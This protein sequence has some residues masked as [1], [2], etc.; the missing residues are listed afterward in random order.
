MKAIIAKLLG[1]AGSLM[2]LSGCSEGEALSRI[3][4]S[5]QAPE[6]K[7][8]SQLHRLHFEASTVRA[9]KV[10]TSGSTT[11]LLGRIADPVYGDFS[12]EFVSQVRSGRGFRFLHEPIG[13]KIDSVRLILTSPRLEGNENALMKIGVY[14]IKG[15]EHSDLESSESLD[16]LRQSAQLLGQV[17]GNVKQYSSTKRV[18][19][20]DVVR[21]ITLPLDLGVGERIYRASKEHPEYFQTQRS[22][23][24][25]VLGGLL[26]TPLAGSGAVVQVTGIELSIYYTYL[27]AS[28]EK[29]VGRERFIDTKQTVHLRG[30]SNTYID[31]L[32]APSD[33]YLYIKQ[34]AGVV[35]A[36]TLGA[37]Q[38][39]RLLDGRKDVKI[40]TGWALADAQFYLTVDKPDD[41]LLNP[42]AYMML[43][44][45]D[46]VATFFH[47]QQTER[48]RAATSYL[49]SH[50]TVETRYYNFSNISRLIAEHLKRHAR[51]EAGAWRVTAPLELRMLP[52]ER[53]VDIVGEN[54]VVTTSIDEYLFPSFVRIDKTKGLEIEVISSLLSR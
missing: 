3:G 30:L 17:A 23:Q 41:M 34:P 26:I 49:S 46:S 11:S 7:V 13:G 44:P 10:H 20:H 39:T 45:K 8:E 48:T 51:Y 4:E 53:T 14:E 50:Y 54:N 18:S 22:F 43:M 33:R 5:I 2:L 47:K 38:L 32:L 40:G 29:K 36:F 21:L 27:N 6:D 42:P 15:I 52:V 12:A 19:E 24:D 25:K 31:N 35:A 1:L 16:H 28:G 9:S 37:D